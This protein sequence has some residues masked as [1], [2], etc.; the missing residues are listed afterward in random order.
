[1]IRFPFKPPPPDWERLAVLSARDR[2]RVTDCC[3]VRLSPGEWEARG[4]CSRCVVE[5][6][7][8]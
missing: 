7:L 6:V 3:G 8:L 4:V 5:E 2:N 1:M